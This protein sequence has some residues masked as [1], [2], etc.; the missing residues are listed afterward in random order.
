MAGAR[1]KPSKKGGNFQG[2]FTDHT[3]KRVYFTGTPNRTETKKIAQQMESKHRQIALGV[4]PPPTAPAKHRKRPFVEVI[5]EYIRWGRAFG[6]KDGKPWT[7]DYARRKDGHLRKWAETLSIETLADLDA[8]LPRVEAVL[9]QLVEAGSAGSTVSYLATSLSSFCEWCVGHG[10]LR[11]NP[12]A[13]LRGIDTSPVKEPRRALTPEEIG[14]L[15]AVAPGWRRLAYAVALTTGLRLGE[16]G[17][18]TART[19]TSRTGVYGCGGRRRR[20]RRPPTATCPP[21]WPK[22]LPPSRT[23]APQAVCT[24]RP[25]A[26]GRFLRAPCCSSPGTCCRLS[27]G[28]LRGR[29][30]PSRPRGGGWTF[31]P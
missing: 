10:Y 17:S 30:F 12:L 6:R 20:T 4:V 3:G 16:L 29:G 23:P 24:R 7:A 11:E 9:G 5:D 28:I 25:A 19:W 8:I 15:F 14:R 13:N 21:S 27:T 2:Y 26:G 22:Q 1:R 18:W 31:T